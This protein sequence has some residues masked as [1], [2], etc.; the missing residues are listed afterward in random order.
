LGDSEVEK[1]EKQERK[2]EER[3][4]TEEEE[5]RKRE[6][7]WSTGLVGFRDPLIGPTVARYWPCQ[8]PRGRL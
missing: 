6:N 7:E 1:R 2:E 8:D 4:K 5:M 3:S